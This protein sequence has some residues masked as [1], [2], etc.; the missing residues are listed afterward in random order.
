M[1]PR[2]YHGSPDWCPSVPAG[3]LRGRSVLAVLASLAMLAAAAR[4]SALPIRSAAPP[5]PRCAWA[6]GRRDAPQGAAR[7][8]GCERRAGPARVARRRFRRDLAS[9]EHETPAERPSPDDRSEARPVRAAQREGERSRPQPQGAQRPRRG[10]RAST[11]REA[12]TLA[13]SRVS[14]GES[15]PR[16]QAC[17]RLPTSSCVGSCSKSVGLCVG[18]E[19][20]ENSSFLALRMLDSEVAQ[21]A[22]VEDAALLGPLDFFENCSKDGN[23]LHPLHGV[24]LNVDDLAARMLRIANHQPYTLDYTLSSHSS[25]SA[26]IARKPCVLRSKTPFAV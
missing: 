15:R 23:A 2:R 13:S 18:F 11:F 3:S 22:R 14:S 4:R 25:P 8:S 1:A 24:L 17:R 12:S 19:N 20:A 26:G 5:G 9:P 10:R 16:N 6:I 21:N 7:A